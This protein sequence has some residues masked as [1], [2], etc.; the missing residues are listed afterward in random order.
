MLIRYILSDEARAPA[1]PATAGGSRVSRFEL[2]ARVA[3]DRAAR[4]Q[5]SQGVASIWRIF[6]FAAVD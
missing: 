5:Q 6:E 4:I 3:P 2:P 1:G